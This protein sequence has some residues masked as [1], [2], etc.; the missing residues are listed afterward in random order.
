VDPEMIPALVNIGVIEQKR[1]NLQ[2]AEEY[3]RRAV[4][5]L[6]K[7]SG[8]FFGLDQVAGYYYLAQLLDQTDRKEEAITIYKKAIAR[9]P[10]LGEPHHN[11]G[12]LLHKMNKI[13]EAMAEYEKA[14]ELEPTYIHSHYMLA[15]LL[16]ERGKLEEAASHLRIVVSIAPGYQ[17]AEE[18]LAN[19]ERLLEK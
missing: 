7:K 1:N 12:L 10:Q 14:V 18:H 8:N 3:F 9:A 16:S 19:I 15:G 13:D 17:K 4:A 6:D 5:A 2:E 11:L